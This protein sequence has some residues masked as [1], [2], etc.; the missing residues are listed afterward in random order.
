MAQQPPSSPWLLHFKGFEL[1]M[2]KL[3]I[4]EGGRFFPLI[5]RRGHHKRWFSYSLTIIFSHL[6][7]LGGFKLDL[8]LDPNGGERKLT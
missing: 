7:D 1:N 3:V 8:D 5:W 6:H 2:L 4:L